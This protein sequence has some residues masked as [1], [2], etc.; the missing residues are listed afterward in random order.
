MP[1]MAPPCGTRAEVEDKSTNLL[2]AAGRMIGFT[3]LAGLA[4]LILA[5]LVLLPAYARWRQAEYQRDCLTVA[6]RESEALVAAQERLI[7]ALPEEEVLTKRL[8]LSQGEVYAANEAVSASPRYP[9]RPPPDVIQ[10]IH[11]PRPA[12]PNDWLIRASVKVN[13]A[14]T[15]RG[16]L[17][18][19][20][21]CLLTAMFLFAPPDCRQDGQSE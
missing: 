6:C 17:L 13:N 20:A 11:Y 3:L 9:R 15:R 12:P 7:A 19:A 16:L 5:G 4:M 8:A 14:G 18:L 21:G 10:P 1:S 2:F